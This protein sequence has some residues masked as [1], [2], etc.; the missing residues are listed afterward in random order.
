MYVLED[1]LLWYGMVS[2]QHLFPRKR[3]T[4]ASPGNAGRGEARRPRHKCRAITPWATRMGRGG[5]ALA[6]TLEVIDRMRK[7][8]CNMAPP[9]GAIYP[10]YAG[11][12]SSEGPYHHQTA[13]SRGSQPHGLFSSLYAITFVIVILPMTR[14]YTL[15]GSLS[16]PCGRAR[17]NADQQ[18]VDCGRERGI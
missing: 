16:Q 6:V 4:G 13:I 1:P 3:C 14:P 12:I 8:L 17:F 11:Y 2:K 7:R 9:R 10:M 18:P 5:E 15:N